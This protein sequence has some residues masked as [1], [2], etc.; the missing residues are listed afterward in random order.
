MALADDDRYVLR[1]LTEARGGQLTKEVRLRV[2]RLL[3]EAQSRRRFTDDKT[4]EILEFLAAEM[5]VAK[6]GA[7]PVT[8]LITPRG[9]G[10]L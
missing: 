9:R 8:W 1:A 5:M 7:D 4:G 2:N 6:Q 10:S 3:K